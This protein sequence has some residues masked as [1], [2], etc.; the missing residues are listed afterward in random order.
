MEWVPHYEFRRLVHRY[1]GSYKVKSFS[2]WDQFL[3]LAFAQLTCR[4][5]LRDIEACLCS[6]ADQL[7]HLGFRSDIARSHSAP[8]SWPRGTL[9]DAN[10]KRD[11]RIYRDLAQKLITRARHLYATE[12]LAVALDQVV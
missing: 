6:R 11:W 2:C 7:Y 9:A 3:C 10:E 1:R 12:E 4:E 5:S 8:S